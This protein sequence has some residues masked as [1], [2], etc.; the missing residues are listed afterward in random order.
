MMLGPKLEVM[1]RLGA[2]DGDAIFG[3]GEWWRLLS[4]SWLHAGL[5]HLASN[6]MGIL[7]LGPELER[8]FGGWR[9][10]AVYLLSGI[11]GMFASLLFLPSVPSV[12]ASGSVFGLMG[13]FWA[14]L[15]FRVLAC[16][17]CGV[18]RF[19]P[20]VIFTGINLAIGFSPY[21]DNLAHLGGFAVGF[22]S[23]VALFSPPQDTKGCLQA[24]ARFVAAGFLAF[25]LLMMHGTARSEHVR[26]FV[27]VAC[28]PVCEQINC[29]EPWLISPDGSSS[30]LW[31]CCVATSP[32]DCAVT[33]TMARVDITC[34]AQG[35]PPIT[36][37]CHPLGADCSS[38]VSGLLCQKYCV[39][40]EGVCRK[41]VYRLY[42][43]NLWSLP[44][45]EYHAPEPD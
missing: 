28:G 1:R 30:Q 29:V 40:K 38:H 4:C 26:D 20:L 19:L 32:V 9:V 17:L 37:T 33:S 41:G 10:A 16:Q 7:N 25:L 39:G 27:R 24:N 3:H 22:V 13:A 31:N 36:R 42:V 34:T 43:T 18:L 2:K 8:S 12:G 35:G 45:L 5:F 44:R 21:V 6:S 23:A 11:G 14:D 15:A